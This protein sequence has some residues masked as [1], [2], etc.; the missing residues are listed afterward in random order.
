M[1]CNWLQTY[2]NVIDPLHVTILHSAISGA[3]F[4]DEL[5]TPP[6]SVAYETTEHGLL[7]RIRTSE[8]GGSV[9]HAVI[10]LV[11]PT[12]RIAP[13]AGV[14]AKGRSINVAWTLPLDDTNTKLFTVIKLPAVMDAFDSTTLPIYGGHSWFDLDDEGHQRFPGDYEAIVGQ[15]P[16]TMHSEEHLVSSDRGVVM[17]R[18]ALRRAISQVGSGGSPPYRTIEN[19]KR[20]IPVRASRWTEVAPSTTETGRLDP[21]SQAPANAA[22]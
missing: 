3:Q 17:L 7:A 12:V 11:L 9:R 13:L 4:G 2:E 20:T 1:P 19:S 22:S 5:A 14:D 18:T 6:D 21:G 15:G 8:P 16:I 10:E